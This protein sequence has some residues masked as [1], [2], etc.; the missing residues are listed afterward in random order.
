[1]LC[2]VGCTLSNIYTIYYIQFVYHTHTLMMSIKY[3]YT[4]VHGPRSLSII[5][6]KKK[7]SVLRALDAT[8]ELRVAKCVVMQ[9]CFVAICIFISLKLSVRSSSSSSS[10]T[11]V[12]TC[13]PWKTEL[14]W[15]LQVEKLV[16]WCGRWSP[17]AI[18]IKQERVFFC[19][20]N[21][22]GQRTCA[23]HTSER[24]RE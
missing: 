12:H 4:T 2:A 7:C 5:P 17:L 6:E 20:E 18:S 8:K 15:C 3:L 1:M 9:S 13:V 14:K 24:E 16:I 23:A 21:G 19:I 10:W 11:V 22:G